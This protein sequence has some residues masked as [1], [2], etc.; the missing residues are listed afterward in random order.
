M[1]KLAELRGVVTPVMVRD[2]IAET[3]APSKL[4]EYLKSYGYEVR[5]RRIEVDLEMLNSQLQRQ[6]QSA[7]LSLSVPD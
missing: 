5:D 1:K 2:G 3:S 7:S 6:Q 4:E